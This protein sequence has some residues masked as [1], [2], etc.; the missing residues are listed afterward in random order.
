[1]RKSLLALLLLGTPAFAQQ[2]DCNDA[3]TQRDMNHCAHERY[4]TADAELNQAWGPAM[5]RMKELDSFVSESEKGAADAL[6]GA[7]RLWIKYRDAACE[8]ESWTFKGGS[9]EPFVYSSCLEDLT[10][11]RTQRLKDLA[12]EY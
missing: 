5:A 11:A 4:M 8:A 12:S 10:I 2:V 1:M 7:Q 9:M 6:L 3:V